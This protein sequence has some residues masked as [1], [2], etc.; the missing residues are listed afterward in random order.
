MSSFLGLV[1]FKKERSYAGFAPFWCHSLT[2]R[3]FAAG[4][5]S[6]SK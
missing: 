5:T 3:V 1:E 2:T 4:Y 6:D